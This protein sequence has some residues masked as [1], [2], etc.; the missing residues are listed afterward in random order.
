MVCDKALQ[1]HCVANKG[2]ISRVRKQNAALMN[3]QGQYKEAIRSFNQDVKELKGKL[4]EADRQKQKFQEEVTTLR[5]KVET[6]RTDAVQ[7]F[8]T[9][10]LFI[11]SCADYYDTG[12][13]DYLK[14]VASA[15]PEL[16]LSEI[17]MDV[18]EPMTPVRNIVTD[19]DDGTPKSKLPPKDDGRIVL[20]QPAVNPPPAPV[21]KIPMVAVD[22][23]DPQPQKNGGNLVDAP[24]T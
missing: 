14:Q 11:D 5:E 7:K 6:V 23:D 24:N 20:A 13:D 21:S 12:F 1:D 16:H 4:E 3:E 2:V 8:K 9:S 18:P 10:Q 15:F 19:D 22:A 17:T